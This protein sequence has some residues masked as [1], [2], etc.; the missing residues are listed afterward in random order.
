MPIL[1]RARQPAH[2]QAQ[3]QPD[4]VQA[5]L[6]EEILEPEPSRGG[7]PAASL[8][9]IDD[10]HAVRGPAQQIRR[11]TPGRIADPRIRDVP[12]PAAGSIVGYRRWPSAGGA[13]P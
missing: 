12:G 7:L 11:D 6:G 4:V 3:D 5:D 1:I 2:L 10:L 9:F 13:N 8:I